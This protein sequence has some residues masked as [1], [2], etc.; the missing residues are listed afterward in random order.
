MHKSAQSVVSTLCAMPRKI[1]K[2]WCKT[3]IFKCCTCEM[4]RRKEIHHTN[5]RTLHGMELVDQ[6]CFISS[7][8]ASRKMAVEDYLTT[9]VE[10]RSEEESVDRDAVL[11]QQ[12]IHEDAL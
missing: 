2:W 4:T 5:R 11:S 6:Y 10:L 9:A 7:A 3:I 12:F 1:K 8:C